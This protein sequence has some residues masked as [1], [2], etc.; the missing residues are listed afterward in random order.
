MAD[1]KQVYP[2]CW[3]LKSCSNCGHSCTVCGE[4]L[5]KWHEAYTSPIW[6]CPWWVKK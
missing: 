5:C 1:N 3:D 2:N 4:I 6:K